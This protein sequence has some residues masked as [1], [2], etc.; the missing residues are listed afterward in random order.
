[1]STARTLTETASRSVKNS[2]A[3]LPMRSSPSLVGE[4][5]R[6]LALRVEACLPPPGA[7]LIITSPSRGDGRSTTALELARALAAE[8][9]RRVALLE[10]DVLRPRLASLLKIPKARDLAEV[11]AGEIG[12]DEAL[13][14]APGGLLSVLLAGPR[15]RVASPALALAPILSALRAQHDYVL[16]DTPPV[17]DSADAPSLAR[18]CDAVLL[19][20]REAATERDALSHTLDVLQGAPVLGCVLNG[21]RGRTQIRTRRGTRRLWPHP[22]EKNEGV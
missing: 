18:Q 12:L 2:V 16:V 6:F 3:S 8:C 9:G 11:L 5:Y 13:W 7:T 22:G 14:S 15:T 21:H 20:V 4:Y 1:M 10:A 17:D 19:V